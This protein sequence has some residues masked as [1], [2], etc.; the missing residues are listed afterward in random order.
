MTP[1]PLNYGLPFHPHPG[2]L[3]AIVCADGKLCR[4]G[5]P[6]PILSGVTAAVVCDEMDKRNVPCGPHRVLLY[7]ADQYTHPDVQKEKAT[8]LCPICNS[9][10]SGE[11]PYY[12]FNC[13]TEMKEIRSVDDVE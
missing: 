4:E 6:N 3:R 10:T 2:L 7:V 1:K 11:G 13:G 12:C 8:P 5:A 9:S